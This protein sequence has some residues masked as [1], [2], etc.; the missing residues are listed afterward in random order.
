[1]RKIIL[2]T[3]LLAASSSVMAA[4]PGGSHCGWGNMLFEGQSGTPVHVVAYTTNAT[5]GNATFGMTSGTNGCQTSAPLTYRGD[6]IINVSYM[7]DELSEDIARGSGEALNAVAVMIGI[8]Q[9]DRARF[10][11]VTHA[12]FNLIFPSVD[13]T[14]DQVVNNLAVVMSND[15]QLSKYIAS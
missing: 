8:E 4:A 3:T 15:K 6:K 10:A 12:N 7:M 1:M 11:S 14:A 5:S 9:E 13:V 2:A